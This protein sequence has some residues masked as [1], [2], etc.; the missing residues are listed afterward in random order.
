MKG[1]LI[2]T[3][4]LISTTAWAQQPGIKSFSQDTA[5]ILSYRYLQLDDN[6]FLRL[7]PPKIELEN[8]FYT[9]L[10]SPDM[11]NRSVLDIMPVKRPE[12]IPD[13]PTAPLDPFNEYYLLDLDPVIVTP[14]EE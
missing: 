3:L 9:I 13:M 2:T 12:F 7:S 10:Q 1:T 6:S 8:N 4:L 14:T 11:K 5:N